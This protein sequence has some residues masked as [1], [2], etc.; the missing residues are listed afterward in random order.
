MKG[1]SF[2]FEGP[3]ELV[4]LLLLKGISKCLVDD[5]GES[6]PFAFIAMGGTSNGSTL[7]GHSYTYVGSTWE[8][9]LTYL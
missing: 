5:Y 8:E 3:Q 4:K 7:E 1:Y 6:R 9:L 2:G